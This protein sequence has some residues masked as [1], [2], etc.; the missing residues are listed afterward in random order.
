MQRLLQITL[1]TTGIIAAVCAAGCQEGEARADATSKGDT[2]SS[3]AKKERI[4]ADESV[5]PTKVKNVKTLALTP[6]TL[7]EHVVANGT[8]EAFRDV[9]YSAE[10]PGRIEHLPVKLG[11]RIR[12]GQVLAR[13]DF[14][15][16]KPGQ[17]H[18]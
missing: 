15:T 6:S 3:E 12:K 2:K 4:E 17:E 14:A 9:T 8:T 11:D 13:I 7:T 1:M 16:L 5:K 18:L 10:V